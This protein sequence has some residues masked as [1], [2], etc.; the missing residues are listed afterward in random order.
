MPEL[1]W[2]YFWKSVPPEHQYKH[3]YEK[4]CV[5]NGILFIR[6]SEWSLVIVIGPVL[7][8]LL[9]L[10]CCWCFHKMLLLQTGSFSAIKMFWE[11][12]KAFA[13]STSPTGWLIKWLLSK[14]IH[15]RNISQMIALATAEVPPPSTQADCD[16]FQEICK[17]GSN[18]LTLSPMIHFH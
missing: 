14:Q 4:C 10:W 5:W 7:M 15:Y 9:M 18:E 1:K 16:Y 13:T 2:N 11:I 3:K 6:S 17:S 12:V 8:S